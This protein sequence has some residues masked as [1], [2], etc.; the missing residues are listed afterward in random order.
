MLELLGHYRCE[1]V[2]K[3]NLMGKKFLH[4]YIFCNKVCFISM[5]HTWVSL[6]VFKYL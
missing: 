6:G 3:T 1:Y 2:N 4:M 5:K